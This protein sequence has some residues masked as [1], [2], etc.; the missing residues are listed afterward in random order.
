[1]D[2]APPVGRLINERCGCRAEDTDRGGELLGPWTTEPA[3]DDVTKEDQ[4]EHE[5]HGEPRLP[6]PPDTPGL[7]RPE[8]SADETEQRKYGN[9]LRRGRADSV[10]DG[11]TLEQID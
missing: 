7:A 8:R 6:I 5:R 3:D 2:R 10:G 4:L 9:Q 1:M 11:R